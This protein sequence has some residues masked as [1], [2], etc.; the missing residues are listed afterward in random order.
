MTPLLSNN[1]IQF[2]PNIF[3]YHTHI[4]SFHKNCSIFV[5][6]L[7]INYNVLHNN[8]KYLPFSK[9]HSSFIFCQFKIKQ[10][11]TLIKTCFK[12]VK[13]IKYY[14]LLIFQN[15]QKAADAESQKPKFKKK[16][17][18]FKFSTCFIL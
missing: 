18:K 12:Y 6:T 7:S 3:N 14:L 11:V 17:T 2:Y 4:N 16:K 5:L 15:M 9:F 1:L 13:Q 10:Q 8:G